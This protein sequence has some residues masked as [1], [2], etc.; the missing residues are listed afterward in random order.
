MIP[1]EEALM[2]LISAP[3]PKL[4]WDL[5]P[6]SPILTTLKALVLRG[7]R[8]QRQSFVSKFWPKVQKHPFLHIIAWT[9]HLQRC[10]TYLWYIILFGIMSAS[11]W[12]SFFVKKKI[13]GT[14]MLF[15]P[16]IT[17]KLQTMK[18]AKIKSHV[19]RIEMFW[20]Q[21]MF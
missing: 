17:K 16:N 19:C 20:Q 21:Q 18:K 11:F 7:R 14:N 3:S 9:L 4:Y 1:P 15:G 2:G 6:Q 8:N 13:W 10:N 12:I 5:N